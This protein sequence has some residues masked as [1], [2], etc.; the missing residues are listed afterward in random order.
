MD[1]NEPT[2]DQLLGVLSALANPHRIRIMA[3]L[4]RDRI[5]VSALARELQMSRPLVHMHLKK[6]QAVGLID[7]EME[8]SESGRAQKFFQ[9][10][11]FDW[12]L[13]PRLI[14][15]A[16]ETL[17]TEN[18]PKDRQEPT[19]ELRRSRNALRLWISLSDHAGHPRNHLAIIQIG[20]RQAR[21]QNQSRIRRTGPR[22][23]HEHARTAF[24]V[25]RSPWRHLRNARSSRRHRKDVARSR[26]LKHTHS[27]QKP[28]GDAPSASPPK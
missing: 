17:T 4:S 13:T 21:N 18:K 26:Q 7:S 8:V 19:H 20:A 28:G 22:R 24:G 10:V 12:H 9:P 25:G 27:P 5:H 3:L 11:D 14:A 15:Q 16:S 6:L 2:G 23:H 1:V